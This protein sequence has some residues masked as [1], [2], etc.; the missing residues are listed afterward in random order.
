M[1]PEAE[2]VPLRREHAARAAPLNVARAR[3]HP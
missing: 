3:E 1:R 2:V